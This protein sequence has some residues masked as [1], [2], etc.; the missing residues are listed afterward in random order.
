[1]QKKRRREKEAETPSRWSWGLLAGLIYS[2]GCRSATGKRVVCITT[3]VYQCVISCRGSSIGSGAQAARAGLLCRAARVRHQSHCNRLSR[4]GSTS[5]C[6][7][8]AWA[9]AGR[10]G[11]VL[12]S[13]ALVD[14]LSMFVSGIPLANVSISTNERVQ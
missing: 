12:S 9:P 5:F 14:F 1:M 11:V 7:A 2:A 4:I 13:S 10:A 8:R 3:R 6:L